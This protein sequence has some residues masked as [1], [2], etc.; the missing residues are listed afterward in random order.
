MKCITPKASQ[1]FLSTVDK[2]KKIFDTFVVSHKYETVLSVEVEFLKLSPLF[3][4]I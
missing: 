1:F 2:A 4:H 3:R